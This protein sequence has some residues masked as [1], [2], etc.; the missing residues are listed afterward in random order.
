[1]APATGS[2]LL[3]GNITHA[4]KEWEQLS[5]IGKLEVR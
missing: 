5:D 4:R 3:I 2:I 1:M